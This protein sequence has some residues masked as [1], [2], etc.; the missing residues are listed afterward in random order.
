MDWK[1]GFQPERKAEWS[2]I[3]DAIHDAVTMDEAVRF[4]LPGVNPRY[5]RIPCPIHHGKDFN[6]SY[7]QHGYKCFVCGASGD[8]ITFVKETQGCA[9]RV[10]AMKRLNQDFNLHLP[11]NGEMKVN[12]RE[13]IDRRRAEADRKQ[14]EQDAWEREYDKLWSEYI[15]LDKVIMFS[16]QISL[17]DECLARRSIVAYLIDQMP[18]EP[19]KRG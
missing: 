18:V 19:Q 7:T 5:N 2:E 9:T 15:M 6:F 3:A 12:F 10:D 4:Y 8:V 11:I 13:E 16:P 1:Q 14:A 17:V